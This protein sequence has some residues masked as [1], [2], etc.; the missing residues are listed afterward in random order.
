MT[1]AAAKDPATGRFVPAVAAPPVFTGP[2]LAGLYA[3]AFPS[4]PIF[5]VTGAPWGCQGRRRHPD[6]TE[7]PVETYTHPD[8]QSFAELWGRGSRPRL[9]YRPARGRGPLAVALSALTT[10]A[11][12]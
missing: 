6:R 3:T 1:T 10:L 5:A 4:L 8:A 11:F 9:D 7:R 2:P 12:G